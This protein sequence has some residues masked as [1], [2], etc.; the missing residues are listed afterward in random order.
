[1]KKQNS[2]ILDLK[3]VGFTDLEGNFTAINFDQKDLGNTLFKNAQSIEMDAFAKA[4]HTDGKAE[5]N[6]VVEGE[7]ISMVQHMYQHRVSQ[8]LIE[9][10]KKIK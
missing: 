1:M 5:L 4:I 6:E 10:I 7:L 3:E 2:R 8:A 9:T